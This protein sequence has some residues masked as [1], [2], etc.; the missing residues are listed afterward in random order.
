MILVAHQPHFMPWLGFLK[1]WRDA[2]V[3]MVQDNVGFDRK[4]FVNRVTLENRYGHDQYLVLPVRKSLSAAI[5]QR[6]IDSG[7]PF[8]EKHLKLIGC[9][10]RFAGDATV[11]VDRMAGWYCKMERQPLLFE[12]CVESMRDIARH[13]GIKTPIVLQSEL[14]LQGDC[15]ND[16]IID[17]CKKLGCDSLCAGRDAAGHRDFMRFD[18]NGI[19]L[20]WHLDLPEIRHSAM[21]FLLGAG[22]GYDKQYLFSSRS[23]RECTSSEL[24]S[25]WKNAKPRP[26]L[27]ES[28]LPPQ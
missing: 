6:E 12:W 26:T 1:R 21:H 9:Y 28:R 24:R 27:P 5:N 11:S 3:F 13:Y 15:H 14:D 17:A 2:D 18:E 8:I 19:R 22:N 20:L 4:D 10:E 16:R 7:Q 25:M 23:F